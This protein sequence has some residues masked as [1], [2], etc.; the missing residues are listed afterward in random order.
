MAAPIPSGT[1]S[2][3]SQARLLVENQAMYAYND[4]ELGGHVKTGKS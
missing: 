1:P 3:A 4:V 2:A